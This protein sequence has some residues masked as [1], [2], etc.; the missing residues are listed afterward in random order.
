[1]KKQLFFVL[2]S[3]ALLL[4][5]VL[6]AQ[7]RRGER[8]EDRREDRREHIG[9]V[10]SDCE[11]RTDEF[12]VELRRFL[13]NSRMAG[14]KREEELNRDA[15]VLEREMNKVK[16]AWSQE[17]DVNKTARHAKRAID[18]AQGLNGTLI[19]HRMSGDVQRTW[20][21]VRRELNRLAEAFDL[22]KLRW[23]D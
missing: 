12:K 21:I 3:A 13:E 8:R 20:H 14:S 4:P 11:S 5:G 17:H 18:A 19:R 2:I 9:R 1:M 16:E 7:P 6:S 22:Q 15:R 10:I 23:A